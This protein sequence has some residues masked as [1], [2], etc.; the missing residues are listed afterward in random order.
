[1]TSATIHDYQTE[2]A[3]NY[4]ALSREFQEQQYY[5]KAEQTLLLALDKLP[6]HPF[7][8]SRLSNLYMKLDMPH[9]ALKSVQRLIKHHTES[10]FSYFL[11]ARIHES[12]GDLLEAI[13]DYERALNN[14]AKDL[15]TLN[16]LLPLLIENGKP[17][18]ALVMIRS[19]S[20][21]KSIACTYFN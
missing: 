18:E 14:S 10:S 11:R 6:N 12:N 8:L 21:C 15:Y 4:L 9:K 13:K 2:V 20:F 17:E 5:G 16:R 1:M 7:I 3:R 19:F